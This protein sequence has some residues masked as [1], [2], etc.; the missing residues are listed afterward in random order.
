MTL[1]VTPGMGIGPEVTARALVET[2]Q[3]GRVIL[4]GVG[5]AMTEAAASVGL[6]L[7][8]LETVAQ[9]EGLP[10]NRIALLEPTVT[11]E[12]IEEAAIRLGAE[13]CLA[14]RADALVTGPIHKRRLIERGFTYTGHTDL[15]GAI[16]GIRDPVMAFVG[17]AL[18]VALV[19]THIPLRAVPDAITS[20]QVC[21]VVRTAGKAIRD[22]LSISAPRIGV[23][24]LNPHA[25]EGG[26]LGQTEARE[27]GPAC[28]ALRA[29]GWDIRGPVSAET[30]FRDMVAG[31]LD[32][33]VAMYHD[34]GLV[35]LKLVDFGKSV[36]WTLGLP[37]V[38]TSVDHGTADD[39]IGTG[40]ADPASMIAALDFARR[41]GC[42]RRDG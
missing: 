18:R 1:V 13:L 16:C 10:A 23:C 3:A 39:L 32:L 22:D 20:Q 6:D 36:N 27:I 4:I 41:I 38:R 40:R 17:G 37:I 33:V 21:H 8:H 12:P 28:E 25:G 30:A 19:T 24:G 5:D 14:G 34:Q 15:L 29:D 26:V 7:V 42:R 9:I 11:D 35:P 31:R 2:S